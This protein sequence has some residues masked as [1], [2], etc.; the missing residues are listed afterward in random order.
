MQIAKLES[1]PII[2]IVHK[3]YCGACSVL[4]PKLAASDD[5]KKLSDKFI[6]VNAYDGQDPK[7]KLYAPD[8]T[9]VPRYV[10]FP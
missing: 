1:K 7:A 6:M 3:A 4:L 9:Y 5:M 10:T 2:L 8:G